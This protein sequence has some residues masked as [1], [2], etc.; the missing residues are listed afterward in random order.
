MAALIC[1]GLWLPF[2]LCGECLSE[3]SKALGDACQPCVQFLCNPEHPFSTCFCLSFFVTIVPTLATVIIVGGAWDETLT[4]CDRSNLPTFAIVHVPILLGHLLFAW[5]LNSQFVAVARGREVVEKF[6]NMFL[7]D[8]IV[9]VYIL[10]LVFNIVWLAYTGSALDTASAEG[11]CTASPALCSM[12]RACMVIEIL[13]FVLAPLVLAFSLMNECCSANERNM[14]EARRREAAKYASRGSGRSIGARVLG[15][16]PI[17][18]CIFRDDSPPPRRQAR[19]QAQAVPSRGPPPTSMDRP[20]YRPAPQQS[21]SPPAAYAYPSDAPSAPPAQY[22]QEPDSP[23]AYAPAKPGYAAAVA[24]SS[25]AGPSAGPSRQSEREEESTS[26]LLGKL[27]GK[28]ARG[29]QSGAA[30]GMSAIQSARANQSNSA[31]RGSQ[32]PH[33]GAGPARY[34]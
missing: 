31:G 19:A 29:V 28:A 13:F 5:Y 10:F 21:P 9:L 27:A 4:A 11:C 23:P 20:Q 7:Y 18:G 33:A 2:K 22:R 16:L 24:S 26:V 8:P 12:A 15:S 30:A 32:P 3:T 1:K 14:E 25:S 6:W 34:P 17:I